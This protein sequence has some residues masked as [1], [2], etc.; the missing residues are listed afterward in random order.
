V[1]NYISSHEERKMFKSI[2][3]YF[4]IGF[5]IYSIISCSSSSVGL[6]PVEERESKIKDTTEWKSLLSCWS[7]L[8]EYNSGPKRTSLGR[9][10]KKQEIALE[11]IECSNKLQSLIKKG[12]ISQ[13]EVKAVEKSITFNGDLLPSRDM[14]LE[15]KLNKGK[16]LPPE[17]KIKILLEIASLLTIVDEIELLE[18]LSKQNNCLKWVLINYISNWIRIH[19]LRLKNANPEN[20]ILWSIYIP[21]ED[22]KKVMSRIEASLDKIG[23]FQE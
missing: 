9:D 1:E 2:S 4:I 8:E 19:Y 22:A 10:K 12:L 14:L 6:L 16:T 23:K 3:L 18:E 11:C 5:S 17:Q 20:Y 21:G 7:K 15:P 13:A